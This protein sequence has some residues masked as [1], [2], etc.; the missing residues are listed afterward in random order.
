MQFELVLLFVKEDENRLP[1]TKV[2]FSSKCA[3]DCGYLFYFYERQ[4]FSTE[5]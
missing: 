2:F 5:V 3:F 4:E 1:E